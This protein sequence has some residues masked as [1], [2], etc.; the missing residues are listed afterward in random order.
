MLDEVLR[1]HHSQLLYRARHH[2]LD[3]ADAE[4]ALNEASLAFLRN[5]NGP[6][7]EDALN[8]LK[9][10]T[11]YT[12]WSFSRQAGERRRQLSSAEAGDLCPEATDR[13]AQVAAREEFESLVC[14]LRALKPDE[15]AA[16]LLVG[17]GF[18]YQEIA[19]MRSWSIR[20]TT[21]CIYEGR[22]RLRALTRENNLN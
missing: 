3:A 15:Q 13:S 19:E 6:P 10:V 20:K 18:S 16:L 9:A 12:A 8:W 11:K 4:D 17:F 5:Y 21:R 2:S 7:G 14:H 22:Q 1:E